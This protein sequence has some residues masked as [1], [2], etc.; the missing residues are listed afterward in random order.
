MKKIYLLF[1]IAVFSFVN[2][3]AQKDEARFYAIDGS[4]WVSNYDR[5]K[6]EML[7]WDQIDLNLRAAQASGKLGDPDQAKIYSDALAKLFNT[8]KESIETLRSA[9]RGKEILQSAEFRYYLSE[10]GIKTRTYTARNGETFNL[11][12]YGKCFD[13]VLK[14]YNFNSE[15]LS[16]LASPNGREYN[17]NFVISDFADRM[18]IVVDRIDRELLAMEFKQEMILKMVPKYLAAKQ[19]AE[20]K[21]TT[22]TKK[23]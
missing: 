5:N 13:D 4:D 1:L 3:H 7:L 6:K 18:N 22:R 16:Q 20:A 2:A 21:T 11:E 14:E 23:R 19:A 9:D 15:I 8:C 10:N 17:I 12:E